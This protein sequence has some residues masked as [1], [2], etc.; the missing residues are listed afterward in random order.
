MLDFISLEF[1]LDVFLVGLL[2]AT[3][4]YCAVLNRRLSTMRDA[5]DDLRQLSI[6][7]DKTIVKSKL[8]VEE[9]KTVAQKASKEFQAEIIQAKELI[10]EL[11]LIN[12]SSTRIADRLQQNVEIVAKP[13]ISGVYDND[14]AG[15]YAE[16]DEI[17]TLEPEKPKKF[18][19][20]AEK[21]LFEM[22]TRAT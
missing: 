16:N 15:L 8:G 10:E 20:E 13:S 5:Q 11:Q 12:A 1:L 14:P 4:G 19:T 3:I 7:F 6:E 21:E 17:A 2:M 9:L 18:R 22:L